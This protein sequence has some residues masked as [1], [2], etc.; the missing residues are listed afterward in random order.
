[1]A[2]GDGTCSSAKSSI[3]HKIA[4]PSPEVVA[5]PESCATC[6]VLLKGKQESADEEGP[7]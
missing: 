7:S 6:Q 3:S 4:S 5:N 1:M 2:V